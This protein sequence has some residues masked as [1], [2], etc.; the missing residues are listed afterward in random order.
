MRAALEALGVPVRGADPTTLRGRRVGAARSARPGRAAL[1]RQQRHLGALSRRARR[2]GP[3]RGDARGRRS[4]WRSARS[5]I[6]WTACGSSACAVDCPTG[7]PPLTIARR[8]A[9]GRSRAHARRPLEPVLLGADAGGRGGRGRHRD[10]GRGQAR[11]SPV[12]RDHAAHGRGLR[13][14]HR[15][16]GDRRSWCAPPSATARVATSSSRT[17]RRRATRSRIAAATGG[18]MT[19]AR[20]R[21]AAPAG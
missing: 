16:D 19:R 4:T 5:P 11:Q 3:R 20:S 13:R 8:R 1:R 21:H 18:S 14:P 9:R 12:R 2:A 17:P 15:R 6:S 10:R 7:C